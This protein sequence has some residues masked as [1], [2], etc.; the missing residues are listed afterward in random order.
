MYMH[1]YIIIIVIRDSVKYS[2]YLM[3]IACLSRDFF[4]FP[5][6]YN[7]ILTNR[8]VGP[9]SVYS[10]GGVEERRNHAESSGSC[11]Y[12]GFAPD[13]CQGGGGSLFLSRRQVLLL[14]LSPAL[15]RPLSLP[16]AG[17]LRSEACVRVSP[18]FPFIAAH[19]SASPSRVLGVTA[20]SPARERCIVV[21][22]KRSRREIYSF[23]PPSEEEEEVERIIIDNYDCQW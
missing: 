18:S 15:P 17:F 16:H 5:R 11:M 19:S 22:V 8:A 6:L 9:A 21:I 3:Y 7:H 23:G 13:R 4:G 20:F 1:L 12:A 14:D 2:V 10:R